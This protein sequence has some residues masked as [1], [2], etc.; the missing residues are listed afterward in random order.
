MCVCVC[1]RVKG[2]A[3]TSKTITRSHAADEEFSFRLMASITGCVHILDIESNLAFVW[4]RQP[5]LPKLEISIVHF[6][7]PSIAKLMN[8]HTQNILWE[9][10]TKHEYVTFKNRDMSRHLS[11]LCTPWIYL[12]EVAVYWW[13]IYV[14]RYC[15]P[16]SSGQ[17]PVHEMARAFTSVTKESPLQP[18]SKSLWGTRT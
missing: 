10:R 13:L 12:S 3:G 18:S 17:L 14:G 9:T 6:L 1:V 16:S 2:Q 5:L 15:V 11:E 4:P 7:R 8:C